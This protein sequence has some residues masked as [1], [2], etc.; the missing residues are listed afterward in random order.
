[1]WQVRF[2]FGRVLLD[3][4][5]FCT[6]SS[7]LNE[8]FWLEVNFTNNFLISCSSQ[9]TRKV[10]TTEFLNASDSDN[11]NSE[12]LY[13]VLIQSN[14]TNGYIARL[15]ASNTPITSFTQEDIDLGRIIYVHNGNSGED[16]IALQVNTYVEIQSKLR[17]EKILTDVKFQVS[18]GVLSSAL[19][20]LKLSV[21]VLELHQVNNTGITLAQKSS[22]LI[23]HNNLAFQTNADDPLLHI[24]YDVSNTACELN[25]VLRKTVVSLIPDV[26]NF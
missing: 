8:L 2:E 23:T 12:I 3:I 16:Q 11:T 19:A 5:V 1:M 13:S 26:L 15:E 17:I 6:N 4:V 21:F 24:K 14:N 9:G 25:Y 22:A 10:I 7:F 18:D 20:F